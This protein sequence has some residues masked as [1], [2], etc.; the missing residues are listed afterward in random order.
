MPS[1]HRGNGCA[2][3]LYGVSPIDEWCQPLDATEV[4]SDLVRTPFDPTGE[5]W[6]EVRLLP[7]SLRICNAGCEH[8]YILVVTGPHRGEVWHDG[9]V[10]NLRPRRVC[11][12]MGQPLGLLEWLSFWLDGV[13]EGRRSPSGLASENGWWHRAAFPGHAV[14]RC[15][16]GLPPTTTVVA[17]DQLPCCACVGYHRE[18]SA[19][20]AR[21]IVPAVSTHGLESPKR[22]VRMAAEG[23]VRA[24]P[25]NVFP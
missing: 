20:H 7:G 4:P 21:I 10:D 8:Y 1:S 15:L 18:H 2:G 14:A 25:R 11:D 3:P 13:S 16:V 12:E 9:D 6:G 19:P 22:V 24:F 17:V 5:G 23:R